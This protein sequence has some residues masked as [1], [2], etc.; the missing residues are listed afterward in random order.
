MNKNN[1]NTFVPFAWDLDK[2][3]YLLADI[4]EFF[5]CP[6]RDYPT[7]EHIERL[8]AEFKHIAVMLGLLDDLINKMSDAV[9]PYVQD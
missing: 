2:A 4:Q 3:S 8:R 5:D 9:K 1:D 6:D 7:R